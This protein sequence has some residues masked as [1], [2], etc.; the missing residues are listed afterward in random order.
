LHREDRQW[1]LNTYH[2]WVDHMPQGIQQEGCVRSRHFSPWCHIR[3][4]GSA[5]ADLCENT[6]LKIRLMIENGYGKG[7][8]DGASSE[9]C[10]NTPHV[11]IGLVAACFPDYQHFLI[12]HNS[13]E[14]RSSAPVKLLGIIC[15]AWALECVQRA[16]A[17]IVHHW[18]AV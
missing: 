14:F 3:Y 13:F 9:S 8:W 6:I 1:T 11:Y 4:V 18:S 5:A 12:F 17:P 10:A 2:H 7:C 15:H 16:Q